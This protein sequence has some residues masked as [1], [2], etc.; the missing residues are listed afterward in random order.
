[1]SAIPELKQKKIA[2]DQKR[3]EEAVAADV[4]A[5]KVKQN[6]NYFSFARH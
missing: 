1:M 3:A 5:R 2:R 6:D 4:A